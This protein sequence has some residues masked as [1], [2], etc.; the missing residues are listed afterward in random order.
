M[1]FEGV[2]VKF[3]SGLTDELREEIWNNQKNILGLLEK[4]NTL[5]IAK[6][7]NDEISLRFP[8]F[9]GIRTDKSV[10]DVNI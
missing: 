8:R 5:L 6:S 7:N 10:E 3:G 1:D 2:P 4:F 9:K